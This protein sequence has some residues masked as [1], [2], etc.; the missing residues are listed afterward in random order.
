MFSLLL[1]GALGA[2]LG[3]FGKC[4]SGIC[5]LTANWWRGAL[6]GAVLGLLFHAV[7]SR[8]SPNLAESTPNVRLIR[9]EQFGAEVAQAAGP[10]VVDF[11][12]T[13][14]G[15]CKRLS[16]MLDDL[17]GPLTNKVKFLKLDVDQSASLARQFEVEGV[18]TLLFFR[19]GAMVNKIVG[20]P[21]R[22]VLKSKLEALVSSAN[23]ASGTHHAD[24]TPA[25][26]N[27]AK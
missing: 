7:A 4:T 25:Q 16:P 10:V 24:A 3:H 13:W 8:N 18:P 6:Y 20:L 22:D 9:E 15:P 23:L 27:P 17:A 19:N 2:A 14:C 26:H 1:G 11:F 12:A 21:R 5:P